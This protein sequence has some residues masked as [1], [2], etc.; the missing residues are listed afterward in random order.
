MSPMEIRRLQAFAAVARHRH[1]G[2]AADDLHL[3][4]S[5]L[6]Q[7]VRKLED[8][9][10]VAL[11]LR[12]T[13]GAE[14]T[15]AGADLLPRAEAILAQ[16]AEARGRMDEHAGLLRGAVRLAATPADALRLSAAVATFHGEHP[17][18]RVALRQA[19]PGEIAA[20]V[21]RGSV[22]LAVAAL[23]HVPDGLRATPLAED[24]LWVVLPPGDPLAERPDVTLWDLR[25]RP[26]VLPEPG[27]PL[28]TAIMAGCQAAGFSPVP[29][30]EVGDPVTVR[31]LVAAGLG[32]SVLPGSWITG[33]GS[34]GAAVAAVRPR[35]A[36]PPHRPLL[37]QANAPLPPAAQLLA[38][39]IA[40]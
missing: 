13:G 30:F 4:Q 37:L 27:V 11:L 5:A 1:F 40:G 22:D 24:P 38:E 20:L 31:F 36:L 35:E 32:V 33:T 10:G 9:L 18:I 34:A 25:D 28:R 3:T 2:R 39:R 15:A 21:A 8:E 6:S 17:G 12:T 29:L 7:Q 23:D 19:A 16:V 26:F 14:L